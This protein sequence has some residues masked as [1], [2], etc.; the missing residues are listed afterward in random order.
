MLGK[1][2]FNYLFLQVHLSD[3]VGMEILVQL[4]WCFAYKVS[5]L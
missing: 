3:T 5:L 2:I 4:L 1:F